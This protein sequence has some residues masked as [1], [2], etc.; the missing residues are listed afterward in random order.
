MTR[1]DQDRKQAFTV[2]NEAVR[3]IICDTDPVCLL[4]SF[5]IRVFAF[6]GGLPGLF[7]GGGW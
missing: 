6:V 4:A 5:R 3:D 2:M 7:R 1:L